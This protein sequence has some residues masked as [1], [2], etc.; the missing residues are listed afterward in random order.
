MAFASIF[1]LVRKQR[2]TCPAHLIRLDRMSS[3]KSSPDEICQRLSMNDENSIT[4]TASKRD[5]REGDD[6][7]EQERDRR[8]VEAWRFG[9]LA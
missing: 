4:R 1:E 6:D 2:G 3:T 9:T 5:A 7:G 8:G